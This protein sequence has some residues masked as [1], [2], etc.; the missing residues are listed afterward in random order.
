MSE[1]AQPLDSSMDHVALEFCR[2]GNYGSRDRN[3]S[4]DRDLW[5]AG[6]AAAATVAAEMIDAPLIDELPGS[7][8][9][10]SWKLPGSDD[11]VC[12]QG[13][14][15]ALSPLIPSPPPE[16][17][18]A[19][20]VLGDAKGGEAGGVGGQQPQLARSSEEL[21]ASSRGGATS[22]AASFNIAAGSQI[23]TGS[24][25]STA[26]GSGGK[27]AGGST[28]HSV[29]RLVLGPCCTQMTDWRHTNDN[30]YYTND[31]AHNTND[32]DHRTNDTLV[33]QNDTND[34]LMTPLH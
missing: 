33:R 23:A 27:G 21:Q 7:F 1:S 32:N 28:Q 8:L 30:A 18:T 31:N 19:E 29:P 4:R 20:D 26:C 6:V 25:D 34:T 2:D 12:H 13:V 24:S 3:G 15:R 14:R 9:E 5:A 11:A 17:G 16:R 22:N 10:P